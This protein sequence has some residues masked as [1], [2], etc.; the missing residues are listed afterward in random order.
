MLA[1]VA[2][3]LGGGLG[4]L[5]G[6][7]NGRSTTGSTSTFITTSTATTTLV[8]TDIVTI[9]A[10][11]ASTITSTFTTTLVPIFLGPNAGRLGSW[12]Q[13][14]SYPFAPQDLSCA[15]YAGFAYCVGGYNASNSNP[16]RL[17]NTYFAP[18]SGSGI[19]SW[20]RTTAYP[21]GVQDE[22][23]VA[24][25]GYIFCVGGIAGATSGPGIDRLGRTSDT[26]YAPISS[27]GI[28]QWS[29]TTSYPYVAASPRCMAYASDIYCVE[30]YFNGTGYVSPAE[31]FYAPLSSN[32]IGSWTQSTGPPSMTAGCS[33]VGGFAYCFGGASCPPPGPCSSPTYF[34]PL[35]STGAGP[36]SSTAEL[37]TAV[38]A[39][40]S[41]GLNFIYYFTSTPYYA[42][43]WSSGVL[44]WNSTTPYPLGFPASCFGY[45]EYVYCI[46]GQNTSFSNGSAYSPIST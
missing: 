27:S 32:G 10:T 22:S 16:A 39:V 40:Y 21:I 23:C 35:S 12:N 42:Q 28:G 9:T 17:N 30:P 19:G 5:A 37:P 25:G 38:Y 43:V 7:T 6:S 13:T 45:S 8:K 2:I 33:A 1:I 24:T 15:A 4:Y 11:S 14:T 18:L 46:G 36:W 3:L 34:A 41:T 26:F 31:L 44:S 20:T 29:A